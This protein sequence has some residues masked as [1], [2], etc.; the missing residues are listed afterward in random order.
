MIKDLG[1]KI[2]L[3]DEYKIKDVYYIKQ[4]DDIRISFSLYKNSLPF[5]CTGQNLTLNIKKPNNGVKKLSGFVINE[6]N[7]KIYIP[8]TVFNTTGINKCEIKIS[9]NM[10]SIT[11]PTFA[12]KVIKIIE[13]TEPIVIPT[14]KTVLITTDGKLF[15]AS[16]N[17]LIELGG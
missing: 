16:N 9:D 8:G 13:E 14:T 11:T 17:E 3:L 4:Y 15:A 2:L 6:N 12:F 7:I 1:R 10:G 5:N